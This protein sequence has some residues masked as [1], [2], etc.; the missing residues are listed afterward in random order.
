MIDERIETE[1][2]ELYFEQVKSFTNNF[3]FLSKNL[4]IY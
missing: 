4:E 3:E 2:D 1:K